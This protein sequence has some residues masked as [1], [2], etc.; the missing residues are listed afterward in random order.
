MSYN[1]VITNLPIHK[2]A[3][4][5]DWES[6][7]QI[8]EKEPELMTKPIN[9]LGETPLMIAVGTNTSHSFVKQLV[10]RIISVGAADQLFLT[11]SS[12]DNPLHRAAKIGNTID[13]RILVEQNWDMAQA[14]DANG[15][16]PLTLAAWH[17]KKSTLRYLL[18]VTRELLPE[19][20]GTSLYTGVAGGDLITLTIQAGFLDMALEIIALHPDIV[21]EDDGSS[22]TALEV[23]GSNPKYFYSGNTLGLWSR[24]I[25][26][27]IP[28]SKRSQEANQVNIF[29]KVYKTFATGFLGVLRYL[30]PSIKDLHDIKVND[31]LSKLL[32]KRICTRVLE[33]VDHDL[34]WKILGSATSAAVEYGTPEVIEECILTYPDIVWYTEE[35]ENSLHKAAKLAPP[36]RLNIVTGAA[37]QLQREIQW[38]KEVENLVEPAYKQALNKNGKTPKVTFIEEHKELLDEAQQWMKDTA[39]SCT[40]VAALIITMAFAGAFTLPGGNEED[41]KPLFLNKG[42]FMLFIVS[43]AI[44]LFSSTASVLMFLGILTARFAYDDFLYNLPK[45]MTIGLVSFFVSLAATMIAFSATLVLV[46]EHKVSWIAAPLVVITCI[47]VAK[48]VS[49]K[50]DVANKLK[51][52]IAALNDKW[53]DVSPLFDENP[54]LM[55]EPINTKGETALMIAVGTNHVALEIIHMHPDI[56]LEDSGNSRNALEVLGTKPDFFPSGLKLGY[57]SRLVYSYIH[58]NNTSGKVV[59]RDT[60]PKVFDK[61]IHDMKVKHSQSKLLTELIC[62]RVTEVDDSNKILKILGSAAFTAVQHGIPEVVKECLVK[63][64]DIIS[65]KRDNPD[66]LDESYLPLEVIKQRQEKVY[67]VIWQ[68]FDHKVFQATLIDEKMENSLHKAGML[69][70]PHRLNVVNG[71]A[72][73][74]QRELQWYKEVENF[75]DPLFQHARNINKTTPQKLFSDEHKDLLNEAGQW[76]KDVSAS[77]T[78]VAALIIT[79]AF[80]GAFTLPGGYE[81]DGKPLFLNERKFMLFIIADA[82]ALF[83][84]TASVVMFL[85]ILTARF[86]EEDFLSKLPKRMTIGLVSLFV[87]LAATMIA[88]SSTLVLVLRHRVSWIAAP[89]VIMTW[90]PVCLF[91]WLQFPLLIELVRSTYGRSIFHHK[92][93]YVIE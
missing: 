23:L 57:M 59:Q 15:H 86:S 26:I 67:N 90:V 92:D 7:A 19:E 49:S 43:D 68:S 85:G 6:V 93:E 75:I 32:T 54:E 48:M 53:D 58:M 24:L 83:S 38:Y 60:Y 72:L 81:A 35:M 16:T 70:P 27:L 62:E 22:R 18:E 8:F 33:K 4:N 12:G 9:Y 13:A 5:D 1:H 14:P 82:I 91:C 80:A 76:M 3:L 63:Y 84:S 44:A 47:P 25:Y 37:L 36:H 28:M 65:Y 52:H 10:D 21:L 42:T 11:S 46:L 17:R 71:A 40:V 89:L 88:F 79:M 51:I 31:Y 55:T 87:S 30:A 78:V 39:T 64:P 45:R 74:M 50:E 77:C 29:S 20:K 34:T 69:A 56:V 41:G 2:A 61:N 66:N 73:Q